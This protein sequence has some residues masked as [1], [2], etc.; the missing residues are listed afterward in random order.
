[1]TSL[2]SNLYR[3]IIERL[4][5]ARRDA[6]ITQAELGERIGQRQTFV[7]K[8]ELLERRIDVAEFISV[9][10]AIGADPNV[11]IAAAENDTL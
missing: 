6:G 3:R 5:Q 9:C 11:L 7:S 2:R 1:M 8:V 10:R 4:V